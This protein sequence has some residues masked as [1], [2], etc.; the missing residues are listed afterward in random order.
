[1]RRVAT[2]V[3]QGGRSDDIFAAVTAEVGRII[4]MP[5]VSVVRYEADGTATE[6]ASF[7][8]QGPLFPIGR[9]WSLDG[10][11]VLRMVRASGEPARIDDYSHLRGEIAVSVRDSGLRSTVGTPIV[12]ADRVWGAMVV[13]G[14]ERLPDDTES[15]LAEFTELL[16]TSIAKAQSESELAASRRRIVAAADDTRR[17][18]ERDLHDGTQQRLVALGLAVRAAEANLPPEHEGVRE[19]LSNVALGLADAVEDLQ[20]LSRGIHPAIL[21]KGGLGPA[22]HTLALRSPVRIDLNVATEER[23]PEPLEVAAYFV[24]SEAL[25]NVSKHADASQ[26]KISLARRDGTLWLS[27]RDDGKG[28]ADFG[29]GSGLV[30]LQDRV[31]ALGGT[32]RIDS[33]RGGGTSLEVSLPLERD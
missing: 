25:A 6:L 28:G 5:A 21:S 32:I 27:V 10:T 23:L 13:S 22:I 33:P 16:A 24:A 29:K 30:G 20:E 14:T 8:P 3:A 17:Q 19:E 1:L 31:E 2:L 7:S 18:I 12:V 4:G 15:R 26:V 11:N 9:R